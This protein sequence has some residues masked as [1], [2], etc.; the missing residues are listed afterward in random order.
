[1]GDNSS[2]AHTLKQLH[3]QV[4]LA[5]GAHKPLVIIGCALAL[6]AFGLGIAGGIVGSKVTTVGKDMTTKSWPSDIELTSLFSAGAL[7]V[8]TGFFWTR[9]SAI[10]LPGGAELDLTP[11]EQATTAKAVVDALP[12]NTDAETVSATTQKVVPVFTSAQGDR[13][14]RTHSR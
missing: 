14:R 13:R 7:L 2:S 1:M 9:I 8:L 3:P 4:G 6:S 10:K 12:A 11:E 5:K